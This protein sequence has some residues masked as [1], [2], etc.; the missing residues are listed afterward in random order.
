MSFTIYGKLENQDLFFLLPKDKTR[1]DQVEVYHEL[2]ELMKGFDI[3][4][5]HSLTNNNKFSLIQELAPEKFEWV[6]YLEISFIGT[7]LGGLF[8]EALGKLWKLF[9]PHTKVDLFSFSQNDLIFYGGTFDPFHEGHKACI[10]SVKDKFIV[11]LI[12]HNP[13]KELRDIDY[14]KHY[15]DLRIKLESENLR[16]FPGFCGLPHPNPT[17]NWIVHF[18]NPSLLMG[19][20]SLMNLHLWSESHKLLN[21]LKALYVVPRAISD[22]DFQARVKVIQDMAPNL[23][24]IRLD[25]HEFEHISSTKIRE[26][27]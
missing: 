26:D 23:S 11:M 20:D 16:I 13:F 25:H 22:E 9:N 17:V 5:D 1:V 12:D 2:H 24:L 10:N 6:N 3:V 27:S 8:C 14:W 18:E 4:E 21:H 15:Q 19:E 7:N